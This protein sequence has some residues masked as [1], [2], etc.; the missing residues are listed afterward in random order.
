MEEVFYDFYILFK[1]DYEKE[2]RIFLPYNNIENVIN[3]Y[4]NLPKE[5]IKKISIVKGLVLFDNGRAYESI[6]TD[7][8]YIY[9]NL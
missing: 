2:F 9:N 5:N 1:N 8:I 3:K 4:R 6:I 7:D